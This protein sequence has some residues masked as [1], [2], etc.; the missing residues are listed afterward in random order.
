MIE[1][2]Y[3][4]ADRTPAWRPL[5]LCNQA[6]VPIQPATNRRALNTFERRRYGCRIVPISI[7]QRM[8][9]KRTALESIVKKQTNGLVGQTEASPSI[10][11]IKSVGYPHQVRGYRNGGVVKTVPNRIAQN[12]PQSRSILKGSTPKSPHIWLILKIIGE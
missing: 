9:A 7:H 5:L 3:R 2:T 8:E 12:Y 1:C 10:D 6:R 4:G 11:P